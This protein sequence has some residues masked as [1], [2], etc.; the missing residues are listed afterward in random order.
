M[1]AWTT[2]SNALV[3]VGAKPFA[4]TLQALR[5]NLRAAMEGDAT[6]LSAGVY[7]RLPA[8][9]PLIVGDSVRCTLA[10][11]FNSTNAA[12]AA[13]NGTQ[14][15]YMQSGTVRVKF[16][17]NASSEARIVRTRGG[18]LFVISGS[19]FSGAGT[20]SVDVDVLP[21]DELAIQNRL[22]AAGTA[23]VT[24]VQHCVDAA[25]NIFPGEGWAGQLTGNPL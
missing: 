1:T 4:T 13:M 16:T 15:S 6:A 3:A 7:L 9:E 20:R 25:V 10:G 23:T 17:Q 2:I 8:L 22:A 18:T 5:D 19:T 12:F 21:G 24:N 14:L 11:P